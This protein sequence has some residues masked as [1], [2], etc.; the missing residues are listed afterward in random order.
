M[1]SLSRFKI[2]YNYHLV[3]HCYH[4][5]YV[6]QLGLILQ[7]QVEY[8]GNLEGRDY[9]RATENGYGV[10]VMIRSRSRK[11]SDFVANDRVSLPITGV[12]MRST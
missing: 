4:G 6:D 10:N 5:V 12:Q 7:M 2:S 11:M 3:G 8:A 9:M 1:Y